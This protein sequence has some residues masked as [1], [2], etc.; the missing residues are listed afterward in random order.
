MTQTYPD[1]MNYLYADENAA[2]EEL[3]I[4]LRWDEVDSDFVSE[5]AKDLIRGI[6][7]KKSKSGQLEAFL[8]QYSLDTEEG[9]ALMALAEA[10]L[11]IPDKKTAG[12]LIKDKIAAANWLD[13]QGKSRDWITRAAGAGLLMSRKSLSGALSGISEPIIRETMIKAMHVMGGQFVIGQ[14]ID[15]AIKNAAPYTE[16]NYGMSYDMLGEGA[17]T[18]K[19]AELYFQTYINA[20]ERVAFFESDPRNGLNGRPHHGI[21]VKLSA[22]HPQYHYAHKDICVPDLVDKLG[23]L[24]QKAMA[25]NLSLTVD[26]E[27]AE[28]LDLSLL[29][30][31]GTL[32]AFSFKGWD[33]FGMAVQAYQKR[34]YPLIGYIEALAKKHD[35]TMQVRLVKGAYWDS[36]IK[37]A[38]V[39]GLKDFPVWSRKT[40]TDVAYLACAKRLFEAKGRLFPMFGTH[41]AHTVMAVRELADISQV[42]GTDDAGYMFQRL[43][44]MGASLF[45]VMG[46]IYKDV[47]ISIYAPV[48]NYSDLLPYLVRRLLENG[49][50]S[51]FVHKIMDKET[52]LDDLTRDPVGVVKNRDDQR[53]PKIMLPDNIYVNEA[54]RGRTN[55][56]GMD[57]SDLQT[58]DA[59]YDD[60]ASRKAPYEATSLVGGQ[61]IRGRQMEDLQNPGKFGDNLGIWWPMDARD[62]KDAFK[63]ARKAYNAWSQTEAS[64]RAYKIETFANLIEDH[65]AELISLCVR[66]AGKTIE[67]AIAE[68]REAIDFCRYYAN[69]GRGL[70]DAAGIDLPGVTGERNT[71]TLNGRGVFVCI[72]PWNFPLA[73]FTGQ[74]VAALMAGN[75]VIAKPAEQTPAI[76]HRAVQLMY[77]AGIPKSAINLILGDGET[78]AALV[79]HEDV[80]GV[81]FT[82]STNVSRH[83]NRMLAAKDGPIVPLIAETGGLNVMVVDSSALTEQ[84]VDDVIKSAFGSA[85]QRC[86]ALRIL[87]LQAD[88]ADK[89]IDMLKGAM[90]LLQVDSP[91]LLS[92]DLGPVID[93]HARAILVKHRKD[94]EG[95]GRLIYE[96]PVNQALR[97]QGHYFGPCT[98]E[99]NDLGSIEH[100]VFGPVLHVVRFAQNQMDQLIE[101]I[102]EKGYGLTFGIHSR[103][104]SMHENFSNTI[105]AGNVYINR[106]MI[107]ATV[108]S[109]PFGGLGLSGTGPKAG[110]PFYLHRFATEK[111]ISI[112]TTAAGGNA[113][114][115]SIDDGEI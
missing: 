55:S 19:D 86:S 74:V 28:R 106:S 67:D 73:I 94:L 31:Q 70:F 95:Y 103:I 62:V 97:D 101:M 44:G 11:R 66:E 58:I 76:A 2:I 51:S 60:M 14:T 45:D 113:S 33:G 112:D 49:A 115:L 96:V 4:A 29:V 72:S 61:S 6:R 114:L 64:D 65:K 50:N 99:I 56:R 90:A 47:P 105:H 110:G 109:Q 59:L 10:L 88:I 12:L 37:R 102:N 1:Y 52:P 17:R 41:N 91:T 104:Q 84:V 98:F 16:K 69:K 3:L 108:G 78:G 77:K 30:I 38:Q 20:I 7:A 25:A 87:C 80:A 36:E 40:N 13:A 63:T 26:A 92:S 54:P 93:E 27:E 68:I 35:I 75:T 5:R 81:A 100:E 9:L 82:G 32:E 15:E 79:Q 83:I 24:A 57:L 85:G 71:L 18:L 46:E 8:Q 34:A 42:G 89:T 39:M 43:H 111:T 22:L 23:F 53:H 107:G 48:G 21:S